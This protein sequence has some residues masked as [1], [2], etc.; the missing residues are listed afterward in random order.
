MDNIDC[1]IYLLLSSCGALSANWALNYFGLSGFEQIVFHLKV[2]LEGTNKQFIKDWFNLCLL[3]SC[4]ITAIVFIVAQFAKNNSLFYI[5]SVFFII[6]A[7]WRIGLIQYILHQFQST[8]LYEDHYVDG[9]YAD[10]QFPKKKRNLIHIYVES[11]ETTYTSKKNGGNYNDDLIK[12]LSTLAKEEINFSNSNQLGGAFVVNG[13]GWTTGGMVAQSSG[14]PLTIPITNPKFS[15]HTPFL[16]GAYA[17][18]D[19]LAKEGYQQEYLIGSNALFGGRKFYF[20]KHGNFRIYDYEYAKQK[21][22]IDDDYDVFWGYE[23]EKLFAFAKEEITRLATADKPF[24]FTML[25]VDNHHPYG[26]PDEKCQ[27]TYKEQLSNIIRENSIKIGSFIDWLKQQPFYENTTI[28]ITG[29]HLS[30]AAQY[31]N[32]TYD[33]NYPRTIFNVFANSAC[34]TKNTK[35]RQFTNLD[36]YPTILASMGVMIEGDRLGL[37]TNL[38]SDKKTLAEQMGLQKLNKALVKQSKYYHHQILKDE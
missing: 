12:E 34:T 28:V 37:G 6:Y 2:P 11:L 31:I 38:F 32:H 25:T 22:K 30:M 16:P 7:I 27:R 36:F 14:I 10:I 26:Y 33:K 24:H 35:Q 1:I 5:G 4:L 17:L 3:R 21:H 13:T 18:G 15:E 8:T 9:R 19:I 29:D 23:D 20:E